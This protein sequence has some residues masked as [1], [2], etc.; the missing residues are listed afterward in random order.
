MLLVSGFPGI[1]A[2]SA[3]LAVLIAASILAGGRTGLYHRAM[4][5]PGTGG[6][7][8]FADVVNCNS[9]LVSSWMS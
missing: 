8:G 3:P 9:H 5:V 4:G 2:L 7:G 1:T 6:T